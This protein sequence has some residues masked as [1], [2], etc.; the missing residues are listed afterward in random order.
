MSTS[1][2]QQESVPRTKKLITVS[3]SF[4]EILTVFNLT[5][6]REIDVA[7]WTHKRDELV[8]ESNQDIFSN[9]IQLSDKARRAEKKLLKMREDLLTE[10]ATIDTGSYYDK[11]PKLLS[12]E[13]YDCLNYMPKPVIHHVHLTAACPISFLVERLCYYD[14]VYYN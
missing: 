4:K 8:E 1:S 7:A 5:E 11:L 3:K 2:K 13:I 10:D 12:S 9:D 6:V 14:F